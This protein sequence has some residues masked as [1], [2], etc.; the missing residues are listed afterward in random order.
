MKPEDLYEEPKNVVMQSGSNDIEVGKDETQEIA[1]IHQETKSNNSTPSM[2]HS[3]QVPSAPVQTTS[4]IDH[5]KD[6][7]KTFFSSTIGKITF[8]LIIA[9]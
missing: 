2:V 6:N 9:V 4:K 3:K 5:L 1:L 7:L 8:I